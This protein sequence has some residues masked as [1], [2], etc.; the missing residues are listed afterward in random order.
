[1]AKQSTNVQVRPLD[2]DAFDDL[3]EDEDDDEDSD[4]KPARRGRSLDD[5]DDEGDDLLG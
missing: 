1:M 2:D 3:G 5:D 4:G